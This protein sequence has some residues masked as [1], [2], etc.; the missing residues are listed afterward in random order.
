ML[1]KRINKSAV[2]LGFS[3]FILDLILK[4]H[5][6]RNIPDDHFEEIFGGL[7]TLGKMP[8]LKMAFGSNAI[9]ILLSV[10]IITFQLAFTYF[11]CLLQKSEA[12]SLFKYATTMIVC[13]WLGN[14][15]DKIFFSN[16]D[17]S[18]VSLGYF[19]IAG[20]SFYSNLSSFMT[21][22]GWLLLLFAIVLNFI[23]YTTSIKT[24]K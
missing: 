23:K 21:H 20:T 5:I 16:G 4:S 1:L 15:L 9:G 6:H 3:I 12:N 13:G 10:V 14:L 22:L 8:N 7:I 18:Y 2:I 11:S 17:T 24:D 19:N